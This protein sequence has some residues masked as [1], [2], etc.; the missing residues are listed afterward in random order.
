[1]IG[2]ATIVRAGD[3]DVVTGNGDRCEVIG[4]GRAAAGDVAWEMGGFVFYPGEGA[5]RPQF[6]H[7]NFVRLADA[8]ALQM[9]YVDETLTHVM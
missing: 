6:Q 9:L 2:Q 8:G 7:S 1:M 5:S 3:S 4:H